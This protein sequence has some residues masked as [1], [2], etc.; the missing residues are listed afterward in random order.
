VK[1]VN[2]E[3]HLY[4]PLLSIDSEH[5]TVSPVPLNEGEWQFVDDL[6]AYHD[7][8]PE[9][10]V[11]RETY[12]LRNL[13]RGRGVGFFEAGNFH[14]DF[15]VWQVAGPKQRIAF[16]D[17]KGII[18]VR[19]DDEKITFH[20]RVKELERRLG[21]PSVQLASYIV[22]TTASADAELRWGLTKAEYASANVLFQKEDRESYV[23]T[24]LGHA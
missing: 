17:P 9:A 15:I 7:R 16:V 13:S 12:L 10:F 3:Q 20:K 2:F 18:Q 4:A 6:R 14:P 8:H 19:P 5:V 21:D 22:S 11:G 1:A 23:G 24:I